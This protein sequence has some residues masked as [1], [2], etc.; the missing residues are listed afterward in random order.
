VGKNVKVDSSANLLGPIAIGDDVEIGPDAVIVGPTTIGRGCKIGAGVVLKRSVVLPD[1]TLASAAF[2]NHALSQ[3]IVLGGDI[4]T[5]QALT[6]EDDVGARGVAA[7]FRSL[8]VDRPIK[9]ET[10]LEGG[11]T[12]ALTGARFRAF[13]AAKRTMDV[14]GSVIALLC[15]LP[16]YP[17]IALAIY[18]NSPGPNFYGA[19][20]L[21]RAAKH[22]RCW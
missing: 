19:V 5:I 8:S 21:G 17:A 16:F 22:F 15:S 2:K 13:Q 6:P 14:V 4:P 3:A 12:P 20:P 10:V 11:T 7:D 18:L 9:I 1:T